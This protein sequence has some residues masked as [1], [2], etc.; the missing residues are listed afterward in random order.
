MKLKLS[1]AVRLAKGLDKWLRLRRSQ[2]PKGSST[3]QGSTDICVTR[4]FSEI[5]S[6]FVLRV[7]FCDWFDCSIRAMFDLAVL[8]EMHY[9]M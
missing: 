5:C 7:L 2:D 3:R 8:P 9:F 1:G 4:E 6:D